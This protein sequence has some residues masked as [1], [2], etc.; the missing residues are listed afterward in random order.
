M[1]LIEITYLSGPVEQRQLSRATPLLIGSHFSNDLCIEEEGVGVLH[2]RISWSG[3]SF[4]VMAGG[5]RWK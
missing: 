2:C 3:K 5:G 4:E 1:S